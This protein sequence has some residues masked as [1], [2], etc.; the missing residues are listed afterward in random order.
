MVLF[1]PE[2]S[3]CTQTTGLPPTPPFCHSGHT[4][5]AQLKPQLP[6]WAAFWWPLSTELLTVRYAML[7]TV[8]K[9]DQ[10]SMILLFPELFSWVSLSMDSLILCVIPKVSASQILYRCQTD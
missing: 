6:G 9:K 10:V 1:L 2:S 5:Q 4:I 7:L 3:V 8:F